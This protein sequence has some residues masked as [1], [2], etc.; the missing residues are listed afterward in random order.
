MFDNHQQITP[1]QLIVN[2]L[3]KKEVL[4]LDQFEIRLTRHYLKIN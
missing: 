3:E 2:R 1:K 4:D